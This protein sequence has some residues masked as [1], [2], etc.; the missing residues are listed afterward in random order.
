MTVVQRR[1]YLVGLLTW[2]SFLVLF[3]KWKGQCYPHGVFSLPGGGGRYY[4]R[5][6]LW[7]PPKPSDADP[8]DFT[9]QHSV[10]RWPW[11]P[12]SR[13]D[14]IELYLV[15]TAEQFSLGV[16]AL[17]LVL[18]ACKW[19]TARR[20]PDIV[21]SVA[22]YVSLSLAIAWLG[23]GPA[24]SVGVDDDPVIPTLA[25]ATAVGCAC[26]VASYRLARARYNSLAPRGSLA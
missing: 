21:L 25:I 19:L 15:W 4:L 7:D 5:A 22:W 6:P 12:V 3:P 13:P 1:L 24:R 20:E 10:L 18:G 23:L 17:G 26:G 8:H 2:A 11:E 14:H 16:L 9:A